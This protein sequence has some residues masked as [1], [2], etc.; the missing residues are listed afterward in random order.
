MLEETMKFGRLGAR[1]HVSFDGAAMPAMTSSGWSK[2]VGLMFT[3]DPENPEEVHVNPVNTRGP[4]PTSI[5]TIPVDNLD[6]L[7]EAIE[8]V[9]RSPRK[10]R[11]KGR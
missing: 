10:G 2:C 3:R 1:A 4:S 9:K 8:F 6:D 11:R 5:L 7:I